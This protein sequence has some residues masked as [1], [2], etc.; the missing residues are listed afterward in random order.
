MR[1][2]QKLEVPVVEVNL[3]SC[4]PHGYRLLVKEPSEKCLPVLFGE[5]KRLMQ[6]KA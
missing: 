2:I 6:V 5:L 1:A 3:E 4:I